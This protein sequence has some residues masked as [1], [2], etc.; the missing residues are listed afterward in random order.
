MKILSKQEFSYDVST[1]TG[2]TDENGELITKS[3]VGGTTAQLANVKLGIKGTQMV[4]VLDSTPTFQD[5]ACGW[6]PTGT[7]EFT[8][9]ALT[10]C[11]ASMQ[12]ALCPKDLYSTY[13][14]LLLTKGKPE[15]DVPFIDQ[16][17]NLKSAQIQQHIEK[18]LW[19]ATKDGGDCFDGFKTLFTGVTEVTGTTAFS[20]CK[21]NCVSGNPISE[22]DL[23]INALGDDAASRD[24]LICWMSP[25]NF[26]LYVQA[27]RQANYFV[28]YLGATKVFDGTIMHPGTNIK[29]QST[30]GL[31]GSDMV[32]IGPAQFMLVG[33]DLMSDADNLNIWYSKDNNELRIRSDFSYGAAIVNFSDLVYWVWNGLS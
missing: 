13:Q 1:I 28:D 24:D 2:F 22:V 7:T 14:S 27:L 9:V 23:L 10:V 12:E 21:D 15:E 19:Q 3:L 25:S 16:I 31:N 11:S 29:I 26:K 33:F 4:N 32:V 30:I 6:N 17:A 20:A 5:Y 18:K 8:Q